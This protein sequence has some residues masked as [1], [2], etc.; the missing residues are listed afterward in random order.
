[1]L[2]LVSTRISE[3]A[4][5]PERRDSLAHD[6]GQLFDR[7]GLLPL[8][9]PNSLADVS[10]YFDLG[11]KGL[12]L[13]GG[14]SLGS[15]ENPTQRDKTEMQLIAGAI[16]RNIPILGVCRGFQMLNRYFGGSSMSIA[17][18]RHV[19]H[20]AVSL[21]DGRSMEVNSFHNEAVTLNGLAA[22]LLPFAQT[23]DGIVEGVRHV[24]L[25]ITAIQWHPERTS[26]SAQYDE[27]LIKEWMKECV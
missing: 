12:L 11:A 6:W 27:Y 19:G 20:H 21:R 18:R 14:D 13:T 1:M 17:D 25:P 4:S 24:N 5:Y 7:L 26:P 16:Q 9:V 2:I 8:L 10:S 22:S 15:K 3:N 23:A